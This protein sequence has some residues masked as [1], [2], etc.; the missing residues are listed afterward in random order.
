VETEGSGFEASLGKKLV[1]PYL[2]NNWGM[3]THTH[4]PNYTGGR[5]EGS[6]SEDETLSEK[7]AKSKRSGRGIA[8]LVELLHSKHETLREITERKKK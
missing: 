1:R 3:V 4:S 5:V 2:K 7:E 6:Q 8:Q